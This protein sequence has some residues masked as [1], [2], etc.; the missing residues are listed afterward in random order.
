MNLIF[1]ARIFWRRLTTWTRVYL[2]SR[3]AGVGSEEELFGRMYL[4]SSDF[5]DLLRLIFGRE[6]SQQFTLLLYQYSII[7]R[8]LLNAQMSG[9]K[10]AIQQ[11]VDRLYQ[12]ADE[13]AAF[14]ASINPYWDQAVWQGYLETYLQYTLEE[15]NSFVAGDYS[16]DIRLFDRLTALTNEI[17][18]YFAEGLYRYITA[19]PQN[20]SAGKYA[21]RKAG[22]GKR[23]ADAGKADEQCFTFQEMNEIYTIRMFW[24][25]LATWV[26][27]YMLSRYKNIGNSKE[28]YARLKLVPVDYVRMIGTI[29]G[30]EVVQGYVALFNTYIDLIDAYITAQLNGDSEA[31][32]KITQ[33]LYQ[34]ADER[35]AFI[36]SINPYWSES[37]WRTRL[38]SNL[39]NTIN[40]SSTLLSGDY[41]GNI[42]IFSTLLNQAENTSNYFAEGLL[43]YLYDQRQAGKQS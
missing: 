28:V 19:G 25:E 39:G 1:N 34:N 13:R 36:S 21:G 22:G 20:A 5:G 29:F 38:Y 16:E 27:A 18:N 7:L 43:S 35:A 33:Q 32:D 17:G 42:D 4:E 6:I 30:E 37:E 8:D 14:L 12:N 41:A 26:R 11:D 24:F 3:Y 40:E 2:I 31:V 23:A 15:A 10:T 9:N